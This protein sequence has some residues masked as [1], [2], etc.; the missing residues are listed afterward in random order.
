MLNTLQKNW[1]TLMPPTGDSS[2]GVSPTSYG[3]QWARRIQTTDSAF[4][5]SQWDRL[6]LCYL[7]LFWLPSEALSDIKEEM[8][9]KIQYHQE[10]AAYDARKQ[11]AIK[12]PS[13]QGRVKEATTR[14]TFYLPLN[15]D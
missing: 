9:Y 12:P 13:L 3:K 1:T 15:D 2:I 10:L 8:E 11:P 6:E 14:P 5:Q 7:A 4:S